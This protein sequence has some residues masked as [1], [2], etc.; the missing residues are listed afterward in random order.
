[1]NKKATDFFV[2]P[3]KIIKNIGVVALMVF[4]AIY[5]GFQIIPSFSQKLKT[6]TA[7]E[8]TVF[9]TNVTTGYIFRNEEPVSGMTGEERVVVTLVRDGDKLSKGQHFANAYIAGNY[10]EIQKQIDD[11]DNKIRV[12]E[13]ST[14]E[15]NTY[16]TNLSKVDEEITGDLEKIYITVGD[17]NLDGIGEVSED[18]LV[19]LNRR[20]AIIGS[21]GGYKGE[22]DRLYAEKRSLENQI[23]AYYD[24]ITAHES[25]YFYGDTDG[26]EK[27]FN[28]ELLEGLTFD[29]FREITNKEPDQS[30]SRSKYGKIVRDYVWYVVCESD[31]STGAKY[32]I[33]K[34]YKLVFPSF[35]DKEMSLTLTDIVK[36]S[37]ES[38][39][40]L[41][42]R[43]NTAL[44]GFPYT[45]CQQVDIIIGEYS[46]YAVPK[47]ALR[48]VD[49]VKGVY[50]L[51]GDIVRFRRV[52][53]MSEDGDY[54]IAKIPNA[55]DEKN[56]EQQYKY[57]S[58][59][60][61]I[62]IGGKDLFD[63]KIV[64]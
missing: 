19:N 33:N 12:L 46:G 23:S 50:I 45:R 15:A 6:E 27:I 64:G 62:V 55:T 52:D 36:S 11:I 2:D 22:R 43:G 39:V 25:G 34:K 17:G 63:G 29:S 24:K 21:S 58:L 31:K 26:F 42:F 4:I 30:I 9:D 10:A 18:L 8:V 37:S 35:S 48:V 3:K 7:L 57:L 51:T 32:Q 16:I 38:T 49:G 20:E 1:M 44:E 56:E 47:E 40:L 5:A 59:Y 54:Y 13:K 60:D 53:I 61:T 14:V 41:I 28:V